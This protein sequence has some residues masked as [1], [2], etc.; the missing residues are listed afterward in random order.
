MTVLKARR[1]LI[2]SGIDLGS[3]RPDLVERLVFV[4]LQKVSSGYTSDDEFHAAFVKARPS[5]LAA[6]L[7]LC[8]KTKKMITTFPAPAINRMADFCHVG[9][10]L[11]R[12]LGNAD[13]Y[14]VTMYNEQLEAEQE[15]IAEG[16][17]VVRLMHEELKSLL[18]RNA[19]SAEF[20]LHELLDRWTIMKGTLGMVGILPAGPVGLGQMLS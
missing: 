3:R 18:E 11:S 15:H 9:E 14:F 16:D 20:K 1:P 5:M 8:V 12:V 2:F 4:D 19:P 10:A 13:D 17:I 7:S 6:L